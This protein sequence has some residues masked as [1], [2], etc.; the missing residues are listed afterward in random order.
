[1][2]RS[3]NKKHKGFTLVE[4]VISLVLLS[5]LLMAILPMFVS[6]FSLIITMGQKTK[7]SN[8]AQAFIETVYDKGIDEVDNI[9]ILYSSTKVTDEAD[10]NDLLYDD[11]GADKQMF[12]NVSTSGS[13]NKVNVMILYNKG[14]RAVKLSALVP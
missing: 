3:I 11:S 7:I 14:K 5:F 10:M 8:E 6:G 13:M 4:I 12:Y 9:A 2:N 1:M